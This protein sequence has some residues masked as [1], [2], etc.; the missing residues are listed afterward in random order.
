MRGWFSL[1]VLDSVSGDIIGMIAPRQGLMTSHG[2]IL[3][4]EGCGDFTFEDQGG[5]VIRQQDASPWVEED[6]AL[7][8]GFVDQARLTCAIAV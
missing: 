6:E 1:P 8:W 2:A 7:K 3:R 5:V 4:Y